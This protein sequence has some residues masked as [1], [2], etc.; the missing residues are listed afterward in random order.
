MTVVLMIGLL[1][2]ALVVP[3]KRSP[4]WTRSGTAPP[5]TR[6]ECLHGWYN[7]P[8]G[9]TARESWPVRGHL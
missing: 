8:L 4:R 6:Q 3:E 1:I 2:L 9:G 5:L 7:E